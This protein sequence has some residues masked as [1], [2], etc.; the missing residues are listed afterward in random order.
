MSVV[1]EVPV[2]QTRFGV[3]SLTLSDEEA[4]KVIGKNLSPDTRK[5]RVK[6]LAQKKIDKGDPIRWYAEDEDVFAS[7]GYYLKEEEE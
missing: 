2:Q 1:I 5:R 3:I 4:E 7:T 6:K